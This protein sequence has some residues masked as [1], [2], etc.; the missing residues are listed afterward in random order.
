MSRPF[1]VENAGYSILDSYFL[2]LTILNMLPHFLLGKSITVVKTTTTTTKNQKKKQN[3]NQWQFSFLSFLIHMFFFL[4]AHF[5]LSVPS[6]PDIASYLSFSDDALRHI[7][8]VCITLEDVF[9]E[10]QFLEFVLS[11]WLL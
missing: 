6:L 8:C 11:L 1:I 7:V 2:S 9:L 4:E 3:P 5:P 10:L